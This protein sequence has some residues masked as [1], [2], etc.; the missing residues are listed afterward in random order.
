MDM[1]CPGNDE[2]VGEGGACS[3]LDTCWSLP[4]ARGNEKVKPSFRFLIQSIDEC[5][6]TSVGGRVSARRQRR[7][8]LAPTEAQELLHKA[9]Q[10]NIYHTLK[11][12]RCTF[13]T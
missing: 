13:S 10:V 5:Y 9:H 6:S 12:S 8:N 1:N 7:N 3:C 4:S 2:G 11:M